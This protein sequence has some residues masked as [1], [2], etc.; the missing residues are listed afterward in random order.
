LTSVIVIADS[1]AALPADVAAAHGIIVVPM[2]LS[3]D[4]VA[5]VEGESADQAL[6]RHPQARVTTS[7]PS[8]GAFL[9]AVN[10]AHSDRAVA[11]TVA[12]TLSATYTAARL[13]AGMLNGALRVVDSGTAAGAEALVALAAA[14]CA[15]TGAEVDAVVAAAVG[16]AREV[17]LVGT[18]QSLD[19]LMK[20]GRIPRAVGAVGQT[21]RLQPLFELRTG[22]VRPLRPAPDRPT[23]LERLL[24]RWR[25]STVPHAHAEVV[26][27]HARA[28]NDAR[29]LLDR[30]MAEGELRLG[31]ISQL[32]TALLSHAGPGTVGLAWRWARDELKA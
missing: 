19:Y 2:T 16:A 27:C 15:A 32:G 20:G 22:R 30:V 23:A 12:S 10:R 4:G 21:F 26:A 29:W 3:I 9:D 18:L 31:F 8:P 24:V 13:A 14:R 5:Y 25:R 28:P 1:A 7:A 11:V 6:I 17:R